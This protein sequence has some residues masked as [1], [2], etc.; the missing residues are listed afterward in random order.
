MQALEIES[1][2]L[3]SAIE[4]LETDLFSLEFATKET[5]FL[6]AI[7]SGT[8]AIERLITNAKFDS[9]KRLL[10]IF[11]LGLAGW[12]LCRATADRLV[13]MNE[14]NRAI[15]ASLLKDW[16]V[17]ELRIGIMNDLTESQRPL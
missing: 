11:A 15:K 14:R 12:R 8:Y 6:A 17:C 3:T 7:I 9:P 13:R 1:K 10:V 4:S 5:G 16:K 2:H